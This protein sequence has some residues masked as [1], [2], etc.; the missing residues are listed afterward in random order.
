MPSIPRNSLAFLLLISILLA[1]TVPAASRAPPQ[2]ACGVCTD[3]LDEAGIERGVALDQGHSRM[4]VQVYENTSTRWTARVALAKGADALRNDSLREG[5]VADALHRART[6]AEPTDVK[7]HVEESTLVV[8]YRD[9][10]EVEKRAGV[11]L[12]TQFHASEP[13][14]PFVSGGE[15]APYPGADE[16]VL[17]APEGYAVSGD[18][19]GATETQ[20]SVRWQRGD[21]SAPTIDDKTVVSFVPNGVL[22]PELRATI[23]RFFVNY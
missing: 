16:L 1:G 12:F 14:L 9:A 15:G 17:R 19:E 4:T 10:N 18:Y 11:V 6:I 5:V 13:L 8:T 20:R 3:A 22:F 21:G 23:T 7:S 2:A